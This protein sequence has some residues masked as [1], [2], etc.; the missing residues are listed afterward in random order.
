MPELPDV[1][2]LKEFIQEN[3]LNKQIRDI[4]IIDQ[5]II[6]DTDTQTIQKIIIGRSFTS[7]VRHGKHLFIDLNGAIW[8]TMH[9]GMTGNLQLVKTAQELIRFE[10]LSIILE[11][12]QRLAFIDQRILGR[13]G[14][15]SSPLEYIRSHAL[16][17][18]ALQISLD[19]FLNAMHKKKSPVKAALMDQSVIA[20]IGNVYADEILFQSKINPF[21]VASQ[22]SNES[23]RTIYKNI[24]YVLNSAIKMRA[25][26]NNFPNSFITKFRK[27]GEQCPHCNQPIES[28]KISGRTTLYCPRCQTKK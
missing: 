18:D 15:V 3:A 8:L 21:T 12:D 5:R 22:V 14:L 19:E 9:F 28:I 11:N 1:E 25:D 7:V 20:G 4:K 10:R 26:R 23:N 24:D 16:G 27:K 2:I 13:V 17:P 6:Q